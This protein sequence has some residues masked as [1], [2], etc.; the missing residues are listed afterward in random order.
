MLDF[1]MQQKTFG[2]FDVTFT[3]GGNQLRRTVL[4]LI[5]CRLL[6]LLSEIFTLFKTEE[7]KILFIL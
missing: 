6:I 7:S 1:L 5:M 3:G 2:D 4:I